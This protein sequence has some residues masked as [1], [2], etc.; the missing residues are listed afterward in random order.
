MSRS[1]EVVVKQEP[2][3]VAVASRASRRRAIAVLDVPGPDGQSLMEFHEYL[4]KG[5]V[6]LGADVMKQVLVDTVKDIKER[7]L[8]A[9]YG[10]KATIDLVSDGEEEDEPVVGIGP[11]VSVV[12]EC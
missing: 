5:F 12:N 7:L 6:E 4:G 10:G 8:E 2:G 9:K 3:T 11:P 1:K